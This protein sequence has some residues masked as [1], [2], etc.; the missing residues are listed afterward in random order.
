MTPQTF[1]FARNWIG[2]GC[3]PR[4]VVVQGRKHLEG[5]YNTSACK[6]IEAPYTGGSWEKF[7]HRV[8][9]TL[10]IGNRSEQ[11]IVEIIQERASAKP[12]IVYLPNA[13]SLARQ[14][15]EELVRFIAFWEEF[16]LYGARG[17]GRMLLALQF[18]ERKE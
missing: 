12:I 6:I 16:V 5:A 3:E 11:V 7:L 14:C 17:P 8:G 18:P 9:D 15:G 4:V 1:M 10:S 2:T 13:V